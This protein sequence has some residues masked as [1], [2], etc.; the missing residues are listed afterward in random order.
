MQIGLANTGIHYQLQLDNIHQ[1]QS[2]VDNARAEDAVVARQR[3]TDTSLQENNAQAAT[4]A[5]IKE[6][7][8]QMQHGR[9]IDTWA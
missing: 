7:G 2:N 6:A 5:A 3:A 4:V 8:Y 9:L 1:R